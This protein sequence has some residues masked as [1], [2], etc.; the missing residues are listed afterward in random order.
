MLSR[1]E[2]QVLAMGGIYQA[3]ALARQLARTGQ[4][5]SFAYQ[6]S[7]AS[8]FVTDAPDTLSIFGGLDALGLGLSELAGKATGANPTDIYESTRYAATM[9]ILATKLCKRADILD[10]LGGK[11]QAVRADRDVGIA[12]GTDIDVL[13]AGIYSETISTIE[14]RI[15]V[16]GEASLLQDDRNVN[17]IRAALLA[18]VR[19]AVL[20]RQLK[21]NRLKWLFYRNRYASVAGDLIGRSTVH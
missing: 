13:I 11:I 18:G 10:A 8:I 5:D 3:S 16:R 6:K 12:T 14:P 7:I 1:F 2:E 19:A 21:G 17:C 9:V 4:C 20:W 15:M